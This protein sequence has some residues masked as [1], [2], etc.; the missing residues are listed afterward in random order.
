MAPIRPST[1]KLPARLTT[2]IW[3]TSAPL[4]CAGSRQ[5]AR[6]VTA[7]E[8]SDRDWPGRYGSTDWLPVTGL[9]Q[10]HKSETGEERRSVLGTIM[11]R[12]NEIAA[13]SSRTAD[14]G[15]T[16]SGTQ[17]GVISVDLCFPLQILGKPTRSCVNQR[18]LRR[19]THANSA[20]QGEQHP[21]PAGTPG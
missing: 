7:H 11:D 15:Q 1:M 6:D 20:R 14:V 10:S 21:N 2:A 13:C 19:A 9:V 16:S 12:Y 17:G 8:M 18:L 5:I 4:I 3:D